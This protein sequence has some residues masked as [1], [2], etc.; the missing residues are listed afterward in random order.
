MPTQQN[1]V[2][3]MN[4]DGVDYDIHDKRLDMPTDM[5]ETFT[6]VTVFD[7]Q[8]TPG[9]ADKDAFGDMIDTSPRVVQQTATSVNIDPNV[10]NLWGSVGSLN[11]LLATAQTGRM[12]EYMMQFT[13]GSAD[14]ALSLPSDVRWVEEPTWEQGSTYQVSIVNNLAIYAGWEEA[15][16]NQTEEEEETT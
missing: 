16:A 14:F 2:N 9:K 1:Y 11:I 7:E 15:P 3:E 6:H 12:N 4:T 10:L 8:G 13:V 5:S